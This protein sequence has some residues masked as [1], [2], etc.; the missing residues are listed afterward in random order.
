[1]LLG[2]LAVG[3]CGFVGQRRG[4]DQGQFHAVWIGEGQD[5]VAERSCWCL[6]LHTLIDQTM[7]PIGDW[8]RGNGEAGGGGK[9]SPASPGGCAFPWKEGQDR[10]GC[11]G[12]IAIVEVIGAGI[13][14]VD[15][16]FHEPET[17]YARIE[18]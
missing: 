11:P 1:M 13:V 5:R 10:S 4:P 2:D 7:R 14:E 6:M 12:L 18:F 9:P 17:E 3:P 15:R 8:G 16:L